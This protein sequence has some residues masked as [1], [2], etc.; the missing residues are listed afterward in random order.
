MSSELQL[1]VCCLSCCGGAIWWTLSK[2]RQAWCYLQVKL[3]D[4]CL[5]ALSV[6]PWPK[7]R[8]INTLPFL[9]FNS[10]KA[11]KTSDCKQRFTLYPR[12][13]PF[14]SNCGTLD[15]ETWMTE[16]LR[17]VAVMF[18]GGALGTGHHTHTRCFYTVPRTRSISFSWITRSKINR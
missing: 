9:S 1:D 16:E 17:A 5:S 3:C 15:H 4:P 2:E 7:R 11:Q 8:Y 13:R 10:A 6:P 14:C 12:M 18:V